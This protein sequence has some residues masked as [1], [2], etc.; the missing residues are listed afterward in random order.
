LITDSVATAEQNRAELLTRR[1]GEQSCED[2]LRKAK[3]AED[4]ANQPATDED[5]KEDL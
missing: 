3:E 2:A 1:A 5:G 4:A